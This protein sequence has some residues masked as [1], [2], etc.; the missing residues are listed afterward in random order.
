M[1]MRSVGVWFFAEGIE[2]MVVMKRDEQRR[3][4]GS[5]VQIKKLIFRTYVQ[6]F[7][8]K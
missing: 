4:I 5:S 8:Q 7:L 6:L 3:D 2:G 1:E